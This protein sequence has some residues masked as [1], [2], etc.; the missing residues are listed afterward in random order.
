[1]FSQEKYQP[2]PPVLPPDLQ[3]T[4]PDGFRETH[5]NFFWVST[6]S[7]LPFTADYSYLQV[8]LYML[9]GEKY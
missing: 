5:A 7:N 1:M 6:S 2:Q 4:V 3:L 8:N 9:Y